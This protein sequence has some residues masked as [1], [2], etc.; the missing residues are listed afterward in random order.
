[1]LT[2]SKILRFK[3]FN[4]KQHNENHPRQHQRNNR[5]GKQRGRRCE[6][7]ASETIP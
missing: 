6:E 1:M 2:D 3:D 4:L 7:R 5:D